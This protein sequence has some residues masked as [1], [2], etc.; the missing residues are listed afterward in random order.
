MVTFLAYTWCPKPFKHLGCN[1]CYVARCVYITRRATIFLLLRLIMNYQEIIRKTIDLHVHVGPEIIPRKFTVPELLRYESGKLKGIAVKNHFFPTIA[2]N[3]KETLA[4]E[5]PFIINSVTLNTYIGGFNADIIRASAQLSSRPIIVW[6][7]TIHAENGLKQQTEEIPAEWIGK[8]SKIT[9]VSSSNISGLSV[10][11]A[12]NQIKPEVI[13]VLK[14]I[15]QYNAILATGH[16]SWQESRALIRYAIMELHIKKIIVT[17]PIYQKIKMPVP[18]QQELAKLGAYMEQCFSMYSIDHIPMQDIVEQITAIGAENCI[19]SSDV[20][21][22]F[23][24]SPSEALREFF[25]LLNKAGI[26]EKE[27]RLMAIENPDQI[28]A[29]V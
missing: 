17:H 11:D 9:L 29:N 21:Q 24:K 12:N 4:K 1:K 10:L 15:K 20:G 13:E 26:S 6:F 27:L 14:A 18:V 8:Q 25:T 2:M 3:I 5:D 16:L 19:L 28:I 7:P 23:S 22:I